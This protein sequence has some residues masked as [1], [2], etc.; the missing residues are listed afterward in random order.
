MCLSIL[1]IAHHAVEVKSGRQPLVPT[2]VDN[3]A[4]EDIE[5]DDCPAPGKYQAV[6]SG[7]AESDADYSQS[8]NRT[9]MDG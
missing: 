4:G 3:E 6:V 1:T 2:A 8:L 9:S 5:T 7:P